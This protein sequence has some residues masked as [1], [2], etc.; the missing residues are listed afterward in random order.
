MKIGKG[1]AL[2]VIASIFG[3]C[4]DPPEFPNV[5]EIAFDKIEFY[6]GAETDSLVLY[7][8]FKDGDGNLGLSGQDLLH[9]S[10]PFNNLTFYQTNNGGDPP[11][12][13]LN[14]EAVTSSNQDTLHILNIPNPGQGKLVFPRTRKQSGY[15]FLPVF[16]DGCPPAPRYEFLRSTRLLIKA[17]DT[18]A[19][20]DLVTFT[21][22]LFNPGSNTI[23]YQIQDTLY[24]TVNPDHY[25]I[26]VD[27]LIKDP[28]N[29]TADPPG[30]TEYD[31]RENTCVSFDGRFPV[32]SDSRS[33]LE[34]TLRYSM[35]SVGFVDVFGLDVPLM[36]RIQVKDRLLNK[37]NVI[38]TKVFTLQQI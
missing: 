25:N 11:I 30:F 12:T 29:I 33:A 27:F 32:L 37:S 19:L 34:G 3:S 8:T 15:D 36:L 13:P 17:A 5:P 22:T 24:Y 16:S 23:Y 28:N 6:D 21:D 4:F 35:N 31:W 20:D 10:A 9:I 1:L 14:T 26:E 38:F 2:L 18:I 7:I